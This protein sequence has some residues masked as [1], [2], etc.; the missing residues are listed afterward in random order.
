M[1]QNQIIDFNIA[2]LKRG[3]QWL[4]SP[5]P[6]RFPNKP[7][8]VL[9]TS[10]SNDPF[11]LSSAP[12][13]HEY[14]EGCKGLWDNEQ[15]AHEIFLCP[16]HKIRD[17][18]CSQRP[19]LPSTIWVK[20]SQELLQ[21]PPMHWALFKLLERVAQ[22]IAF[23]QKNTYKETLLQKPT[24]H[25]VVLKVEVEE[26][27]RHYNDMAAIVQSLA[28]GVQS[29]M[30]S[31][32]K[33][34]EHCKIDLSFVTEKVSRFFDRV[35][36]VNVITEHIASIAVSEQWHNSFRR[37]LH[38]GTAEP[39]SFVA[40]CVRAVWECIDALVVDVRHDAFVTITAMLRQNG[41][42]Y[43]GKLLLKR[44]PDAG[45]GLPETARCIVQAA[46]TERADMTFIEALRAGSSTAYRSLVYSTWVDAV[47]GYTTPSVLPELCFLDRERISSLH[48]AF[49]LDLTGVIILRAA[50]EVSCFPKTIS[51]S[52]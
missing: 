52:R 35:H 38:K 32:G 4:L 42:E 34:R 24:Q 8:S 10:G 16:V 48:Q 19:V 31:P 15:T 26:I 1:E 43:F 33:D 28:A 46:S 51:K 17:I 44:L 18:V 3:I 47:V 14:C 23:L 20:I 36:R 49:H 13:I 11:W 40:I 45:S 39:S 6:T 2:H 29:V 22:S 50:H 9:I 12:E 37:A 5:A 25:R 7:C 27:R 41:T 30:W 21:S